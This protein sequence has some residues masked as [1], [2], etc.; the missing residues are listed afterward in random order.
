MIFSILDDFGLNIF[1]GVMKFKDFFAFKDLTERAFFFACRKIKEVFLLKLFFLKDQL[2][3][4]PK[5]APIQKKNF[6][7][8]KKSSLGCNGK[9]VGVFFFHCFGLDVAQGRR[10]PKSFGGAKPTL[11]E[12]FCNKLL[13][14]CLM[15][16]LTHNF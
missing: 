3:F 9:E 15:Q 1:F 10:S 8:L 13:V 12:K 11:P 16:K 4:Q 2:N 5:N 14:S 7:G 6:F